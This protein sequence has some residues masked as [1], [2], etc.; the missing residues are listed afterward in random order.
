[1]KRRYRDVED[2]TGRLH[3]GVERLEYAR[4]AKCRSALAPRV[5]IRIENSRD[6]KTEP[7]VVR[8]IALRTI[9]PAPI[10]T[11]GFG[12]DSRGQV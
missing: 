3:R 12:A 1:M 6:W 10:T 2:H 4:D 8:Q 9:Q 7:Q 5:A 11:I